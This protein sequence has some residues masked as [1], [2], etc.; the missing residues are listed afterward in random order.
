M[1]TANPPYIDAE[2][3][4]KLDVQVEAYEPHLALFGG[5]DGLDFYRR[6]V[7]Q[8]L[9]ALERGGT[10]LMEIGW[11]QGEPVR[12]MMETYG[13]REIEIKKDYAGLDRLAKGVK[14]DV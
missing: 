11:N 9:G 10:L 4:K 8:A 7:P 5:V 3:M 6:I 14:A 1:I 13:Y 2:Q 12:K